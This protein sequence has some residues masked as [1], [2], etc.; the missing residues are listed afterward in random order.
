MVQKGCSLE[1]MPRGCITRR[2]RMRQRMNLG[3]YS[4]EL[5]QD[6]EYDPTP[7]VSDAAEH[8]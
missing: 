7:R 5:E 4:R 2:M 8:V 3:R 1:E 6:L